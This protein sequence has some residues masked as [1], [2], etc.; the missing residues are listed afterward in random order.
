VVDTTG[1]RVV[2]AGPMPAGSI[3]WRP[4]PSLDGVARDRATI[5]SRGRAAVAAVPDARRLSLLLAPGER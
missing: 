4:G 1:L 5:S 2:S 3:L